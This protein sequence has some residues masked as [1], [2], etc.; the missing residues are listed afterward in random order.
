MSADFTLLVKGSKDL[1]L[2]SRVCPWPGLCSL[3]HHIEK[4]SR[5]CSLL[6]SSLLSHVL[7]RVI[8]FFLPGL[9]L[10]IALFSQ[11]ITDLSPSTDDRMR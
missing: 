11:A 10:F 4:Q 1:G 7:L 3:L 6:L 5:D 8:M 2:T 9:W